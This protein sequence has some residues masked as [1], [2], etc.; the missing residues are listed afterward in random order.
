MG[1]QV[2]EF[3]SAL[4]TVRL[5]KISY[6]SM[7]DLHLPVLKVLAG[8]DERP[9]VVGP[10]ITGENSEIQSRASRRKDGA[11]PCDCLLLDRQGCLGGQLSPALFPW[12]RL[13]IAA[14]LQGTPPAKPRQATS[15]RQTGL[16]VPLKMVRPEHVESAV[17]SIHSRYVP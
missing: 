4:D 15:N 12:W 16:Q 5:R 7:K 9:Q 1:P 8:P 17:K 3:V 13:C 2:Q 11:D 10:R 14:S 6:P